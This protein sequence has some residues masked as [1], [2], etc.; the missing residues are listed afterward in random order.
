MKRQR[1]FSAL[2][3]SW[4]VWLS[5]WLLFSSLSSQ[6]NFTEARIHDKIVDD[7][8]YTLDVPVSQ[9]GLLT[10]DTEGQAATFSFQEF[11]DLA[12]DVVS[13]A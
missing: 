12:Y 6:T 7:I 2:P 13:V 3:F 5:G 10:G 9:Q 4:K 8:P 1:K 11:V